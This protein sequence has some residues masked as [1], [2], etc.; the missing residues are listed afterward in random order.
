MARYSQSV[1]LVWRIAAAEA[2]VG[3]AAEIEPAHLLLGLCKLCDLDFE[4]L[5]AAQPGVEL[6]LR[7][8]IEADAMELRR[9]FQQASLDQTRFRR[10]LRARVAGPGPSP[11]A[12][13]VMHRSQES[14]QLFRRAEETAAMEA[15]GE[16]VL[17]PRHLLRALLKILDSP[18]AGL[19]AD[20]GAGESLRRVV[21]GASA[22]RGTIVQ[23]VPAEADGRE[24]AVEPP[25]ARRTPYLDRFGRDLTQLARDG[26][27]EPVIGRGEEMRNLV[28]VMMQ[29]RKNNPILVGEAGVGKTCIVEGL[30]QRIVG[31]D[32]PLALKDKRIVEMSMTALVAGTKYRGEFEE[33]MEQVVKEAAE[34]GD[35]ILF[36]DEVH[37]VLG[38]GAG[39]GAIDAA[40]ILKPTLAQGDICCIGA[41]TVE[42]YRKHIEKDPA[43]ERRFQMVWVDEPTREEAVEILR[44]LRPRFQG[45]HGL[46]ITDEAI[47][48]AVELSLRYLTDFRLPDKAIDLIDHACASARIASLSFR[49]DS[50]V[51][52]SIGRAEIAAV[53]AQ[54]CRLPVERLTEDEATRL[55][56]ME[57][58]LRR[59]VIG[60]DEAVHAVSEVIRTARAGLKEPHRPI[61]VF[62]FAGAT[63]TGKTE[64]AKA[65]AEFLF[66]DEERLIRIDMSEYMEKHAVSRLIGAPPGYIGHEE[67]G[68]LTGRVRTNPYS[69]VLF[70]DVEKAHPEVFD[71]FLQ[72]FDDGRLTDAHGRRVSFSETVIIL[73]SNLGAA[74]EGPVPPI[75]L[76]PARAAG[77]EAKTDQEAYRR[78]IMDAVRGALRPELLNRI[79]RIVFFYPLD[80]ASVRQIIDKVLSR[81]RAR[82]R[83]RR[84][85]VELGESAYAL[86][87]KEG[88]RPRFGAREMERAID[89]LVVQPLGRALIEGRFGDGTMVRV[90]ARDGELVLL[91]DDPE[92]TR[93]ARLDQPRED[94]S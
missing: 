84:V 92:R 23:T 74:A 12:G 85:D 52:Q 41:T 57:E 83:E 50:P 27:L 77:E 90:E 53:V 62:I 11:F 26:R 54:R 39:E 14:R 7:Q 91:E 64:L 47:E 48:A 81:L 72:M 6:A 25:P 45:H 65:L 76:R 69:V 2:Y 29:K 44:G 3:N 68:Q 88:F 78:R 38:A 89:R 80:E 1:M 56:H 35:V 93:T 37:T 87:M 61:G 15:T 17:R 60:Q 59:R 58:I 8:E 70:D 75:G 10:R 94:E 16:S 55:L 63:G 18:W 82:L 46:E 43:L 79:Q 31:P 42:E 5:F 86:L 30:A 73:T 71:I 32:A 66:D 40:S 21:D 20:M 4:E 28:R 22:S 24:A 13:D 49:S 34:A 33:R 51:A 19:L 36:I 9:L 67:Q